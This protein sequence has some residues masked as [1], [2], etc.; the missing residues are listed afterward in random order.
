M[1]LSVHGDYSTTK[2][3][4]RCNTPSRQITQGSASH[5]LPKE[6]SLKSAYLFDSNP[7]NTRINIKTSLHLQRHKRR[8]TTDLPR[9]LA[10]LPVAEKQDNQI[11]LTTQG[12]RRPSIQKQ[13]SFIPQTKLYEKNATETDKRSFSTGKT[14]IN[15]DTNHHKVQ[16]ALTRVQPMISSFSTKKFMHRRTVSMQLMQHALQQQRLEQ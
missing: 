7:I 12:S 1:N 9:Y 6:R 5:Y 14:R 16:I 4:T 10:Q 15:L 11:N 13:T 8:Q 2:N 3:N